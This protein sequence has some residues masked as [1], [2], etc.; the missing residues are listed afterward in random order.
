MKSIFKF[1]LLIPLLF[2]L[3]C[4][5]YF[6]EGSPIETYDGNYGYNAELTVPVGTSVIFVE[7][8]SK[9]IEL[10]VT[11][12]IVKTEDG[13]DIEPWGKISINLVSPVKTVFNAYYNI[14][15]KK[16]ILIENGV[17]NKKV[18]LTKS[19]TGYTLSEPKSYKD[20]DLGFTT[21]HSSG[22]VM[23]EDSWPVSSRGQSGVYDTDFNDCVIDYDMEAITVP[24]ELLDIEGWREQVKVVLHVRAVGY[25]KAA[26]V[27][28]ILEGFNTDYVEYIDTHCSFDSW[29]NPHGELPEWT[30]K[31]LQENSLHYETNKTRPCVE[32]GAIFRL[33]ENSSHAGTEEYVRK[34][35]DGTTFVTVMNPKV[36][37]YWKEPKTEQYSKDLEYIYNGQQTL[38][39]VQNLYYY[40]SIPGFVNVNGGLFTYTVIYHM[41]QR[42]GMSAEESSAVLENM[43]NTVYVTT[44]QNF[45]IICKDWT[46]IGLKGYKPGDFK[47]KG[48]NSY[49]DKYNQIVSENS[50][51][52][53]STVPYKSKDG[54]IWAFKCP[55]LT[56][57]LWNKL[58]FSSAYPKYMG[59]M[60]SNGTENTDWYEEGID[61]RYLSCWW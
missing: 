18:V 9:T 49:L 11:P 26:R 52:L 21:Y 43:M 10:P 4:V 13:K 41:K 53:D 56:R 46:P 14:N 54:L 39:S 31:K 1:I 34:N 24:D 23:F 59:W 48:C 55:T 5:S 30:V 16:V 47:V 51:V 29:Q 40:N 37:N 22:V 7:Y 50:N 60:D 3:S 20:S 58:N 36:N 33:N 15:G 2:T 6:N 28:V 42:A 8:N 19:S 17:I 35:D 44:N 25:T 12:E 38:K 61:T 57:H 27:G 45:Y 32:I